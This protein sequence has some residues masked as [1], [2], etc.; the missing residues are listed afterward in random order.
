MLALGLQGR[1]AGV[2]ERT[3]DETGVDVGEEN[4]RVFQENLNGLPHRLG[5][6]RGETRVALIN[7]ALGLEIRIARQLAQTLGAAEE[8]I[9]RRGLRHGEEHEDEDR[10]R[11]PEDFPKRPAPALHD[12]GEARKQRADCRGAERRSHPCGESVG[13][14]EEAVL[15]I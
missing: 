8:N 10:G 5:G 1:K 4:G 9:G 12:D 3:V 6:D 13:Q 11:A 7:L 15:W 2:I 14:F